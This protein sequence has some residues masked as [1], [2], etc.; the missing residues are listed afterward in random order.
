VLLFLLSFIGFMSSQAQDSIDLNKQNKIKTIREIPHATFREKL[1]WPHRRFAERVTRERPVTHNTAYISSNYKRLVITLPLSTRFLQ[2]NLVDR[3]SGNKLVFAP[4]L[5]YH[6]GISVSSR[7]ASFIFNSGIKLFS[8]SMLQKG[9]TQQQDYQLNLYGRKITTDMFVQYYQGFYIRNSGSFD[10]YA[11]I[12]P[13]ALRDDVYAL[14]MGVSSYYILNHRKFSYGGSFAFVEQQIKSAGSLL[15]GAYYSYFSANGSPS[16][17]SEPF[18]NDFDRLS[19]IKNAQIHDFGINIGYIYTYVFRKKFSATASIVQGVGGKHLFYR[20]EDN[21]DYNKLTGGA[22]KL[23][24]RLGVR[25]DNGR[26]FIGAMGI[27][28][29]IL[30]SGQSA[31]SLSYSFGKSTVYL[32]YRFS[33]LKAE[34]KL[35]RRL[36]LIDY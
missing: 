27:Y 14:H 32:G 2:F 23:H 35:L 16:L 13:Y 12:Q 8:G 9:K 3:E 5:E 34:R 7:W 1:L 28:D 15:L 24:L 36:Q 4:N 11:G 33:I 20:R 10:S 17:I 26:C 31:S 25:Y 30:F 21:S 29:H 22:G 18:R 19:F 6:L